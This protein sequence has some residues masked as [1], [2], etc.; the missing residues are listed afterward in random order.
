MAKHIKNNE[1]TESWE[2]KLP[3]FLCP[4]NF[5]H[6]DA[7]GYK[8]YHWNTQTRQ[9]NEQD[10]PIKYVNSDNFNVDE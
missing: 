4:H 9:C 5:Y 2:V 6:A 8:C 7:G 3:S 10:C 1:L